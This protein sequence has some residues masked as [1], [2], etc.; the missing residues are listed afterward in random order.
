MATDDNNSTETAPVRRSKRSSA[1]ISPIKPTQATTPSRKRPQKRA[2]FSEPLLPQGSTGLTPAV[3]KASLKTPKLRRA[4]TPAITR[5]RDH[6]EIQFTPFREVLDARTTRR[7][8]RHGLSDEMNRFDAEKKS[9]LELQRQ[10]EQ[11]NKEL[12]TL[13]DELDASKL[14]EA[15]LQQCDPVGSQQRIDELEA[16]VAELTERTTNDDGDD[17]S[18][19]GSSSPHF[20]D[21]GDG[22]Q[23]YED[24]SAGF[25]N[26]P[27][28]PD[29]DATVDLELESARQEKH[30][31]FR[32]SQSSSTN[33][34]Q[35]A[36]SPAR[37]F[38][39][40]QKNPHAPEAPAHDL[41]KELHAAINRAEEAEVALQAMTTEI[42]SLGFACN[43]DDD[44][45]ECIASIKTHFR[46]MRFELE[47]TVPGETVMSLDYARLMPEMLAKLKAVATRVRDREAELKSMREQQ[48]TLRGNFDHA[49][50]A[51][52]K[53]N[54]RIKELEDAIDKNAEEMLEQRMRA[55]A[56]EREA[57]EH[58][59]NQQCLI[60]AI[61]KYRQEV[62]RL[63][64]LVELVEAE[65]A[66]RLQDVR[67]A[68]SA[69]FTQQLSDLDAKVAAETRGR[70]AA[71]ES[72]VERLKK[73]N[74]LE[75]NLSAARQYSEDIKEELENLK[76]QR[77]ASE[78]EHHAEVEALNGRLQKLKKLN[79]KLE[80]N[81][82]DESAFCE[83]I[84]RTNQHG[85]L[86]ASVQFERDLKKY[87]RGAKVRQANWELESDDMRSDEIVGGGAEGPLTPASV[88][89]FSEFSEIEDNNTDREDDDHVQGRVE[90]SRGKAH[91]HRRRRS[92]SLTLPPS[93]VA[94]P[95]AGILKKRGRRRY[96]SGIGMDSLS[97]AGDEAAD[98]IQPGVITPELSSEGDE[99]DLDSDLAMAMGV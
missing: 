98:E 27:T 16:E 47:R 30:A 25:E 4:S 22:F 94:L 29:D 17:D 49:L 62:K 82:K 76:S 87:I 10:L 2:R 99:I 63:E 26:Q 6:D 73:I 33:I 72:A 13:K 34:I 78:R 37:S 20:C 51:T 92:D 89:R 83:E 28:D 53:A 46:N 24:D 88:V 18:G 3:G 96:D 55:Q 58:E 36:D 69:E 43:N 14:R 31:L 40:S 81:W 48:R 23:I 93:T 64:D 8:R 41:S 50:I 1:A 21:G 7:I 60:A 42:K 35:F 68:T 71:E 66:A 74:A 95:G 56:L 5:Y 15:S 80:A 52:E 9:K 67:A 70:R 32:S 85:Q 75:S 45:S 11:K 79:A 91:H 84:M 57:R 61:E 39:A 54:N 90:L 12:Q 86:R 65:Q 97:E 38:G 77:R 44:A 19:L 59:A